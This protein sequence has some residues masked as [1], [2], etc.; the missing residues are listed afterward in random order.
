MMRFFLILLLV[1]AVSS[2]YAVETRKVS[3]SYTYYAPETMSVEEAKRIALERAKI[4]AIED[5]FG[6]VVSQKNST[7]VNVSN[8]ETDTR[9]YSSGGSEIKGEWIET[10]GIPDYEI[11]YKD[12]LLIVKC[13]VKGKIRENQNNDIN[14]QAITL[15]N[16]TDLKFASSDFKD[17]DEFYL[18]FSSPVN[19]FLSVWMLDEG[20][21]TAYRILPY[22]RSNLGTYH[23]EA[24]KSYLFFSLNKAKPEDIT[25]VDEFFMT[26]ESEIEF[27]DL[28]I[29]FSPDSY[30]SPLTKSGGEI[31]ELKSEDF[32]KWL[33]K[34]LA[35]N[36]NIK[37][38]TKTLTI[39]K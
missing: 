1:S 26:A 23:V 21:G 31:K 13:T 17:G 30:N 15:C 8:N 20:T 11:S 28:Y 5:E 19:G 7:V 18:Q 4:L 16:G 12:N 10:I 9:F 35:K 6:T 14:F 22:Q 32:H 25:S 38:L 24:D 37:N 36:S 39:R 3:A 29:V 27:N 2:L 33:S 34:T